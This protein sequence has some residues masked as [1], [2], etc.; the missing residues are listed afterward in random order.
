MKKLLIKISAVVLSLLLCFAFV[1]CGGDPVVE[2]KPI[3]LLVDMHGWMPTIN[4]VPTLEV[5]KVINSSRL[6][7]KEF[8]KQ[9]GIKIKWAWSKPVGGLEDEIGQWFTTQI[10]GNSCPAIAFSWGTRFQDRG[11]YVDLTEIMNGQNEF[12]EGNVKWKDMYE[13]YLFDSN[14]VVD[15]NGKIVSV[16][17]SLYPG[18]ATG[19]FYNKEIFADLSLSIPKTFEELISTSKT[20]TNN[21]KI[22]V[23]P[24]GFFKK[25]GLDQW[26]VQN[27]IG[28]P[29]AAKIMSSLDLNADNNV[30]TLETLK[31]V[32]A[33]LFN[34]EMHDYAREVYIQAKRYFTEA[35][36]EGWLNTDYM[37]AWDV[38]TIGMKEEGLWA[39]FDEYNRVSRDYDFGVFPSTLLSLDTTTHAAEIQMTEKGPYNPQPNLTLNIMKP[40]VENKP[41]V[42]EAAIKFLKFL[43]LPDNVSMMCEEQGASLGAVLDSTFNPILDEYLDQPFPIIPQVSW[44][45]AFTSAQN[46]KLNRSFGLW[47]LGSKTTAEFYS[48]VVKFQNAGADEMIAAM[49]IAL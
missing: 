20:I 27:T 1:S 5:P 12:M 26:I 2:E 4:E 11:Y 38:G 9:T 49:G 22:G 31:G 39:L 45:Q 21:G 44:P 32:K 35:L 43:T 47:V 42:L 34:P 6:I 18:P 16:P 30:S 3:E 7:A 8:E 23:A 10:A 37:N 46:D 14:A 19:Y 15:A 29:I 24:W 25:Y 28:V 36:P 41:K 48:D 17:I 13:S 40:A 33:N